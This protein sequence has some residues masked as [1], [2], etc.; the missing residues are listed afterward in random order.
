LRDSLLLALAVL[1]VFG[2]SLTATFQFDDYAIFS[3]PAI[4][5]NSGWLDVWRPSQTRPL[6]WFTFWLNHRLGGREPAGY[7]A[8]NLFLHLAAVLVLWNLLPRIVPRRAALIASVV[9]ALHPVVSEPV[10]YVFARG[11]LLA[12]LLCLLSLRSWVLGRRWFAVLWFGLALLAKEECVSFPL[13]LLLLHFSISRNAAEFRQI[14]TMLGLSLLAGLRVLFATVVE[15]GSG[16]GPQAGVSPFVYLAAQGVVILRYLRLLVFPWGFTADP[17]IH[18]PPAWVAAGAWLVVA[19]AAILAA[20]RFSRAR[21][22]FWFLG[23]LMLLLPS[24][25]IFPAADLAA[26]RRM[27]LPMIAF[28]AAAGM[29]LRGIRTRYVMVMAALLG[30][31]TFGR[32]KVWHDE[33]SLWLEAARSSSGKLRPRIQLARVSEPSEAVALLEEAKRLAQDD[34]QV[35]SS[36]G[37]VYLLLGKT[38]LALAEFGRALALAPRDAQAINNRGVA[39]LALGQGEAAKQD[40]RRALELNPCVFDARFNLQRLGEIPPPAAGCRFSDE[41]R[42]LLA[43][44]K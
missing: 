42:R 21:E 32:T 7:H 44:G 18:I 41:Q 36:L 15:P 20:R 35:A 27:Y 29:V 10:L 38:D 19:A 23:G 22:G 2:L 12:T 4:T 40:F 26:D 16:A 30:L 8:V 9:F 24:S 37:R 6:T 28:A 1:A 5:S 39:L 31:L 14:A 43:A 11:T 3:D 17:D 13:F 25:S 33:R 34:P